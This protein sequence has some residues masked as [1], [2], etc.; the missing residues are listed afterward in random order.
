MKNPVV[1]TLALGL[2]T[3]FLTGANTF[4]EATVSESKGVRDFV[5]YWAATRLLLN[6]GN[7]Y[8][9]EELLMVQKTA[10]WAGESA[11]IMWNP[12]WT[13]SLFLP[14]GILNFSMGQF[15]WL[16]LHVSFIFISAQTLWRI[17]GNSAATRWVPWLLALTFIPVGFVLIIGQVSPLL[18]AGLTAFLHFERKKNW[19]ALGAA[20]TILS[21]KPHLLYLFW[22][23]LILWIWQQRQWRIALGALSTGLC[24]ALIPLLLDGRIYA[25]YFALYGINGITKPLDWPAPTLRNIFVLL[26]HLDSIWLQLAPSVLAVG[27][28]LYYWRR[29]KHDWQWIEHLPLIVLVSVT[30][31]AFAWTYDQVV[32]LPAII[33][34]ASWLAHQRLPWYK[35]FAALLYIAVDL[36]HGAMRVFVA[37]ELG[38][39]WLAPAL[40]AAYL[41]Y[42]REARRNLRP[43]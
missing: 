13:L 25:E 12:P 9:P 8:S 32:F 28:V 39:F 31:S 40:L 22:I 33:Q 26:L 23:L 6:G 24:A 36:A 41:V 16:L 43:T 17:Y 30:T 3:V 15:L 21:I 10:G 1:L 35:S 18:L 42:L 38:Y 34:G 7:P 37:E 2:A 14:F 29:H 5:E 20:T 27:W 19:F 4:T 11:L